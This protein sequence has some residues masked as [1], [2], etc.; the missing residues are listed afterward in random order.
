M[1]A[2][3]RPG[4][5]RSSPGPAS[6]TSAW[7]RVRRTATTRRPRPPAGRRRR[8]GGHPS[9]RPGAHGPAHHREVLLDDP[10]DVAV[11]LRADDPLGQA[12]KPWEARGEDLVHVVLETDVRGPPDLRASRKETGEADGGCS[13]TSLDERHRTHPE[14][15]DP[16]GPGV[17]R[18]GILGRG[19][20][21]QEATR[22]AVLVDGAPDQVPRQ[23]IAWPF[24]DER[25]RR[26]RD[27]TLGLGDDD[28]E[29]RGVI[30]PEYRGRTSQGRGRLSNGLRTLE[31]DCCDARHQLVELL[32]DD[33]S[34]VV[35]CP[36]PSRSATAN[37]TIGRPV[38]LQSVG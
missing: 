10:R 26:A 38:A 30:E 17:E 37:R 34:Q 27:E 28:L 14:R 5:A 21:E 31:R 22:R 15:D 4:S 32:L 33:P 6:T 20:G 9:P 18:G 25:C 36:R 3:P 7:R 13:D 8:L 19:A 23:P 29:L 16:A 24:V 35:H 2:G 11:E 1:P 12:A